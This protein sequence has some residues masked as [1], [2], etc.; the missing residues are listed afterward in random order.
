MKLRALSAHLASI[1]PASILIATVLL[2]GWVVRAQE[3]PSCGKTACPV[4]TTV[5]TT[6]DPSENDYFYAC[7]TAAQSAYVNFVE[8]V[9]A[10]SAM[11][12]KPPTMST[13]TGD[14]VLQGKGQAHLDELRAKS[15]SKTFQE[16]LAHC[17]AKTKPERVTVVENAAASTQFLVRD[18]SGTQTWMPKTYADPL[19][20]K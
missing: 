2:P 3:A 17:T 11:A 16:A 20:G 13:T 4:G 15:G 19:K 7:Q 5:Q 10:M 18:A 12:F 8:G 9:I 14:P 1:L 6:P